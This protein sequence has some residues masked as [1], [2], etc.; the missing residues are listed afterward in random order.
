MN[1]TRDTVG[2]STEVKIGL[3]KYSNITFRAWAS[4]DLPVDSTPELRRATRSELF[5]ECEED[6]REQLGAHLA[7]YTNLVKEG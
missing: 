2:V 6:I 7:N 4:R 3:P 1:P 5:Q